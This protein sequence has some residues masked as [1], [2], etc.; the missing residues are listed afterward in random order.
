MYPYNT[1][2]AF[3]PHSAINLSVKGGELQSTPTVSSLDLTM[4]D[5]NSTGATSSYLADS[6]YSSSSTR[7]SNSSTSTVPST[8]SQILDLTR[9][10]G[11]TVASASILG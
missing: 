3:V 5:G 10:A 2:G 6:A 9:S 4:P 8:S 11:S 7:P 1:P